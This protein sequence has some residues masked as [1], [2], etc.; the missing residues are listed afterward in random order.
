MM[1]EAFNA[2]EFP[3]IVGGVNKYAGSAPSRVP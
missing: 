1:A 3:I 2:E